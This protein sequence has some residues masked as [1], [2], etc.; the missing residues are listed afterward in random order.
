MAMELCACARAM[1]SRRG[2]VQR[3]VAANPTRLPFNILSCSWAQFTPVS[4]RSVTPAL[5]RSPDRL[6][7]A[8]HSKGPASQ[9]SMIPGAGACGAAS[10]E[11]E[12]AVAAPPKVQ[13]CQWS[14]MS[15]ITTTLRD[16]IQVLRWDRE[17]LLCRLVGEEVDGVLDGHQLLPH[18]GAHQLSMYTLAEL[19]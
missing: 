6:S 17:L 14:R 3:D 10:S 15:D 7:M 13:L 11:R 4:V 16:Y 5:G 19:R 1:D 12:K 9:G 2:D 8:G 18:G